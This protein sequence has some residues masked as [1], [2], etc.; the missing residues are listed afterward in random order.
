MPGR[1]AGGLLRSATGASATL[2]DN[3][4]TV[5]AS[6]VQQFL[7]ANEI[8]RKCKIC[9]ISE[10]R[11]GFVPQNA[12]CRVFGKDGLF[13]SR[14]YRSSQAEGGK[15]PPVTLRSS[16]ASTATTA[17][18]ATAGGECGDLRRGIL[19][20]AFRALGGPVPFRDTP[21]LFEFPATMETAIFVNRHEIY[22]Y[23][24]LKRCGVTNA[25]RPGGGK[26]ILAARPED[27]RR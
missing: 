11:S 4:I 17:C 1:F 23:D 7:T 6:A 22:L 3:R 5:P 20:L 13:L 26:R 25:A 2:F 27:P 15:L 12:P 9:K 14:L 8:R 19:R 10:H 18:A 24:A 21:D 16:E